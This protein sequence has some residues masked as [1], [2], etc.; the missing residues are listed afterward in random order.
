MELTGSCRTPSYLP[1]LLMTLCAI[2]RPEGHFAV[3]ARTAALCLIHF[4]HGHF[5]AALLHGKE[6][7]MALIAFKRGV[8]CMVETDRFL[9]FDVVDQHLAGA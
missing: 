2:H 7:G 8:A 9:I 1:E 3:V 6:I 5:G 4:G